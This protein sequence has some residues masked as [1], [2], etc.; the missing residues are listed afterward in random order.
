MSDEYSYSTNWMGPINKAWVDKNGSNWSG[1]RID[2]SGPDTG[3]FGDEM[4]VP[5]MDS[6]DWCRLSNWLINF[7]TSKRLNLK[8]LLEEYYADGNPEIVWFKEDE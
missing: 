3:M 5:I 2:I 6:A 8:Q 4:G 7:E 1:G